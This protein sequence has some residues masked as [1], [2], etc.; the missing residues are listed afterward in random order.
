MIP[1]FILVENESCAN[2]RTPRTAKPQ[3]RKVHA[4]HFKGCQRDAKAP[5]S[6]RPSCKSTISL[7]SRGFVLEYPAFAWRG[8]WNMQLL[9][10]FAMQKRCI[11]A[12]H[13]AKGS[14]PCT[15]SPSC[16]N[17][18]LLHGARIVA[19]HAPTSRPAVNTSP[20]PHTGRS[21]SR[22]NSAYFSSQHR[23]FCSL[24][25]MRFAT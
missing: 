17:K 16:W 24:M 20:T 8:C 12:G 19:Q 23:G 22:R 5:Y 2:P 11:L 4:K 13:R 21:R 10:R 25:P 1:L 7:H 3:S 15:K 9:H 6:C 18:A 14:Y